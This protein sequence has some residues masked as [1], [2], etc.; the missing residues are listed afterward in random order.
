MT[1]KRLRLPCKTVTPLLFGLA[2]LLAWAGVARLALTLADGPLSALDSA[3]QKRAELTAIA[4]R[5]ARAAPPLLADGQTQHGSDRAA[6]LRALTAT[7]R[8][9]GARAGVLVESAEPVPGGT[10]PKPLVALRVVASGS[11]K[12]LLT[13]IGDIEQARPTMRFATWRLARAG[14]YDATLR[15]DGRAVAVMGGA[16]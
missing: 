11:E 7:I 8:T 2:L 4:E 15:F 16:R 13:F 3:R 14:E 1:G 5:P 10:L 6:A 12:A 9:T